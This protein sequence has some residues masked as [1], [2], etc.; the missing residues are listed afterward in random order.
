MMAN[1][2]LLIMPLRVKK[3]KLQVTTVRVPSSLYNKAKAIVAQGTEEASSLNDL[4]VD[5]LRERL[6]KI[7]EA[8]IDAEFAEMK[9]DRCYQKHATA[10]ALEFEH[11][12]WDALKIV[13]RE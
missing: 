11:S 4:I 12:D 10:I 13:G 2:I 8:Q 3:A 9:N 5:S 7:L 1:L 6:R